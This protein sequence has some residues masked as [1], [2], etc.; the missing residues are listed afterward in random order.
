MYEDQVE[1][2]GIASLRQASCD[3]RSAVIYELE[4]NEFSLNR[5]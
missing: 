3:S 1:L 2:E 4:D 5:L